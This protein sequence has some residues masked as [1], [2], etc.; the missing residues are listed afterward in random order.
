MN[1]D[2]NQA[3][4]F[5]DAAGDRVVNRGARLASRRRSWSTC[6][7]GSMFDIEAPLINHFTNC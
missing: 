7:V 6:S 2:Q 5:C 4:C 1:I 3:G